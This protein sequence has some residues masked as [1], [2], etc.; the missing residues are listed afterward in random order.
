MPDEERIHTPRLDTCRRPPRDR[1]FTARWKVFA[2]NCTAA[3]TSL[4][5]RNTL[6][7][8]L[9]QGFR[10]VLQGA[11]FILLARTLGP[12]KY[13]AFVGVTSLV[14]IFAPFAS[15]GTGNLLIQNV[16][17]KPADFRQHWGKAL[18]I[19]LISSAALLLLVLLVAPLILP[20]SIPPALVMAVALADLFFSRVAD[21]GAQ[22]YQAFQRLGRTAQCMILPNICR[23]LGVLGFA[24][25]SSQR[26]A[27]HWSL[28][29]LA[30]TVPSGL[31]V[32]WFVCRELGGPSLK[33]VRMGAQLRDGFYFSFTHSAAGINNDID[34]TMLAR[35]STL[36]SVGIYGAAYRLI[37][38]S[39]TPV[40]SLLYA[41]YAKFFQHGESGIRGSL[42]FAKRFVPLVS[43][44][45]VF[46]GAA[47]FFAAP[48]VPLV[49]G[50]EYASVVGV[51]RWLSLLP[52]LKALHY[53]AADALTGAGLQ[54]TRCTIQVLVAGFNIFLNLWLIPAYS[55]RG[56]AWA[57]LASDGFLMVLMWATV[58][59]LARRLAAPR[60]LATLS[61]LE[62]E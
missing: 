24:L 23:L 43:A 42:S 39:F 62:S 49:L 58:M 50:A 32:V 11:Y 16:A 52:L 8:L 53:F 51:I 5:A 60:I 14:F 36:E 22:A 30:S 7:M 34:K 48:I 57:S 9:G 59:R 6:W 33:G 2:G 56:A 44:Y 19:T 17:R 18:L 40:R 21:V 29:Y 55:W 31:L 47:L 45:G 20:R 38:V 28:W 25:V 12:D 35:F 26:T 10:T 15:L 41:A 46:A 3:R 4:L 61:G 1:V 13:G 54:G 37:D 27:L